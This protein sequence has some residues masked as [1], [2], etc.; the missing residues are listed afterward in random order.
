MSLERAEAVELGHLD[1]ERD[2]V[3]LQ[4][5]HLLQRVEPVARGADDA[6]LAGALDELRDELA[7]EGA[8]VDDEHRRQRG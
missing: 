1:V 2:D 7:H 3:R 5:L 8:V 6:K 4:R